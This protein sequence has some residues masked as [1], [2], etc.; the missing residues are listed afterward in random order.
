MYLK[1]LNSSS[2]QNTNIT[3]YNEP[4]NK[5]TS[6]THG[7]IP[8]EIYSLKKKNIEKNHFMQIK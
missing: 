3:C 2:S 5:E 6:L 1:I 4:D 7:L 8:F